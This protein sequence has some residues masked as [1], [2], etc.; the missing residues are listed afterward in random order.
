L[1]LES[2]DDVRELEK[3]PSGFLGELGASAGKS[4]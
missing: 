2:L 1:R 3:K 4:T